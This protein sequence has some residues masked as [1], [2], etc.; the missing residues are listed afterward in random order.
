MGA[1]DSADMAD[2]DSN[3]PAR[4]VFERDGANVTGT[5]QATENFCGFPTVRFEGLLDGDRISGTLTGD[6]FTKAHAFG[7]I[8]GS[9]LELTLVNGFGFIPGG[10]MHLHR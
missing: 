9:T 3:T 2:C 10:R 7:V 1:F 8:S 6:R 5:L 4:A